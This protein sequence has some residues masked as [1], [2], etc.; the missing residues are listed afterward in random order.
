VAQTFGNNLP[1]KTSRKAINSALS[2]I[3]MRGEILSKLKNLSIRKFDKRIM[4]IEM[5]VPDNNSDAYTSLGSSRRSV[6]RRAAECC[7]VFNILI[8]LLLKENK[9]TSAPDIKKIRTSKSTRST[10]RKVE[11]WRF[12]ARKI[13]KVLI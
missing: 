2:K 10:R 6:I 11:P 8:S 13:T 5:N 1:K 3:T 9:A 4:Q 12:V 7:F